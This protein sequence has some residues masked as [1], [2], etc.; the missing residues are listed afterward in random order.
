MTDEIE[1]TT[2]AIEEGKTTLIEYD[3]AIRQIKWDTFDLL[4]EQISNVTKEAD[5]LIEL[6]SGDKLYDDNGQFT[7]QGMATMGLHGQN[8]NT[9]M[10][11]ADQYAAEIAN[12]D[13]LLAKDPG[14]QELLARRQELVEA[15]QESILAAKDEREAIRDMVKEGIELELDALQ[16]RI[17]KYEESL[18]AAKDLYDY[19]KKVKEQTSEIADLEKQMAAYA[20]DTSEEA[21][22]KI[23][24]L[25]VS[26]EDAKEELKETEY[27]KYISDQKQLLDD[28]YT[29]YET[30]L[31][32]RLDNIDALLADM[33]DK[34]NTN[35]SAISTT[36]TTEATNVGYDLS[37]EMQNIWSNGDG[38]IKNV[39]TM[40]STNFANK[41]TT[42]NDALNGIKAFVAKIAGVSNKGTTGG[43]TGSGT[44]NK[45]SGAANNSNQNKNQNNNNKNQNNNNKTIS[46]GGKI[47]ASGAKIYDY[48]GDKYGETQF[49]KNDPIYKV[50]A[51]DGNWIKARYHKLTSGVSGWFKKGDV[52][53]YAKGAK[54]IDELQAAWTQENGREFIVRPSDGAILTPLA[55]GDSVLDANASNNI[56]DMANN[57]SEFIKNN[58]DLGIGSVPNNINVQ[59]NYVQNL[60]NVV[61]NMPNVHNYSEMLSAMQKDKNFEKLILSMSVDRIAGRSSLAKNKAI[62]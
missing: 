48:K 23:Q 35:A 8:Y 32:S 56:W 25:K 49:Y 29:E 46:T 18:D 41:L 50:L 22:A 58:L 19:Q 36:I 42:V 27:D 33:I 2:L 39:I 28:L 10:Y 37:A 21:R 53:A 9:H 20:G 54:Y 1:A 40:Y 14:D 60:D 51:I 13:K 59:N 6:M 45:N 7:D 26:L 11:Q 17:D 24:E 31:N 55:K 12:V 44:S 16:E 43:N 52:K 5:F 4:Q 61:F 3:N 62:R 57:P 15:Q 30:V 34:V 38:S 47:K